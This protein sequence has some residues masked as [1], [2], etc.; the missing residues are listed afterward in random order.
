VSPLIFN[1]EYPII[2]KINCF[3]ITFAENYQMIL[4]LRDFWL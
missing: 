4:P 1:Q 2:L 3:D